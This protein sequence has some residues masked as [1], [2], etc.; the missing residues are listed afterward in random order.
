MT[1]IVLTPE[2]TGS[3]LE[4]S[5]EKP[6]QFGRTYVEVRGGHPHGIDDGSYNNS[7][8]TE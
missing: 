7:E 5:I 2:G 8:N 4:V 6:T 3:N 1:R